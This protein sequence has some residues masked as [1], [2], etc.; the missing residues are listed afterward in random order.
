MSFAHVLG[1]EPA[2]AT[3]ERAL[4]SSKLHHA[5]RFEGPAG[6]GKGLAAMAFARALLCEARAPLA[7]GKCGSC[8]RAATL[9]GEDPELPAHADLL[10]IE[11]GLYRRVLGGAEASGIGVE[12]VRRIVLSRVGFAPHEG[13]ALVCVVRGADELTVSAANAL[14]KTLEEPPANTY[15]VLVTSRP[16]RLL[17]TIRSRTLPVRFGPL[18]DAVVAQLMTERGLDATLAPLA[19]GSMEQALRL[20][21]PELL[22]EQTAFSEALLAGIEAPDLASALAFSEKLKL[23]RLELSGLLEHVAQVLSLRA[24]EAVATGPDAG[25]RLARRYELVQGALAELERNV[26]PQL[27]L[28]ALMTRLRRV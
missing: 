17:D 13:R 1:Q 25:R 10:I 3:L 24:R 27:T 16:S 5:Y 15:F 4:A 8:Q 23:E 12:Q 7:C 9:V 6:V 14:L 2:V 11:R 18:P 22:A 20:A 28:E 21:D 19:Q 26:G